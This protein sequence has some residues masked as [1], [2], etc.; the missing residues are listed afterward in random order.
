MRCELSDEDFLSIFSDASAEGEE[1]AS[2]L[3]VKYFVCLSG[4]LARLLHVLPE[5]ALTAF[6]F[7]EFESSIELLVAKLDPLSRSFPGLIRS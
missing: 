1:A 3:L 2:N 7:A 5:P 6:Y 4:R